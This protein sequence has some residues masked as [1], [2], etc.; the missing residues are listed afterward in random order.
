MRTI[1]FT[2]A[3]L[4]SHLNQVFAWGDLGHG[5]VGYIAEKNLSSKARALVFQTIG[6]EPLAVAAIWADKVRSDKRFDE[7]KPYH[8]LE[9]P[10]GYTL[11]TLPK[12]LRADCDADT[13]IQKAPALIVGSTHSP[14][15]KM[16]FLRY[17]VHI[18]GDVHQPLHIGNGVD[19]GANLCSVKVKDEQGA[20][21]LSNLH[22]VWDERTV[23]HLSGEWRALG[24]KGY[25]DDAALGEY[26]LA[27]V[28]KNN[29]EV[30]MA[31]ANES[32]P[33]DWYEESRAL[34]AAVYPDDSPV[35]DP[36]ERKYCKVI[37]PK[38]GLVLTGA[39]DQSA[40]PTIDVVY[41]GRASKIVKVQIAKAGFRLAGLINK[42]AEPLAVKPQNPDTAVQVIQGTLLRNSK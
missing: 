9:I 24:G 32:T 14:E 7:L 5:A 30:T 8:F 28:A 40:V 33:F 41:F 11:K 2:I 18:V 1:I 17:L 10:L 12:E 26:I 31:S 19:R 3:V 21:T 4:L 16:I 13:W 37:D 42:M 39:F 34:H 36:K 6:L 22:S 27:D 38:T 23:E 29:P 15:Q 20:V 35:T 25:F